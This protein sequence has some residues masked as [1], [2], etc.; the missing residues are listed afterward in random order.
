MLRLYGSVLRISKPFF[1]ISIQRIYT[2]LQ[3]TI[4]CCKTLYPA[5]KHYTLLQNTI[6]LQNTTSCCK[7]L[8]PGAKHYKIPC[9]KTIYPAAKHYIPLQNTISRYKILYPAA[10]YYTL[11]QNT[12]PC[13]KTNQTHLNLSE[14]CTPLFRHFLPMGGAPILTVTWITDDSCWSWCCWFFHGSVG[15]D[16]TQIHFSTGKMA[17]RNQWSLFAWEILVH[18]KTILFWG[19]C[20]TNKSKNARFCINKEAD[21]GNR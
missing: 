21:P 9:C 17:F 20:P 5:A 16:T 8:Y 3:N 15:T 4:P 13:C 12:I 10:K 6:P 11:Q 18:I 2:L 14:F 19:K 1:W 7:T